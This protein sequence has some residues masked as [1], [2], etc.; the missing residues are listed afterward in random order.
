MKTNMRY[1]CEFCG[2]EYVDKE[3]CEKCE[4]NH[5][6]ELKIISKKYVPIRSDNT[7]YPVRI[8]VEFE[9]GNV[10]IYDRQLYKY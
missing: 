4:N 6:K 10:G 3:K 1:Q 7:G 9:D 8:K 2:T 5:K